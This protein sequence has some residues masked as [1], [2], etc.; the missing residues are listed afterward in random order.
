CLFLSF[1]WAFFHSSLAPA[2][3]IGAVWPPKGIKPLNPFSV[4]LLN[5]AVLLSSGA[6]VT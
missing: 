1:F 5:T 4:S 6:T 3:E 2:I